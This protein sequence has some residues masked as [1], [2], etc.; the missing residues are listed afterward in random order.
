MPQ[1]DLASFNNLTFTTFIVIIFFFSFSFYYITPIWS[2]NL[3]L[4]IKKIN[5]Y[6][7]IKLNSFFSKLINK[8]II[9]LV[10]KNKY[11]L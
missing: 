4:N 10:K 11:T 8:N 2:T 6:L 9:S 3:K 5:F 1:A 7:F